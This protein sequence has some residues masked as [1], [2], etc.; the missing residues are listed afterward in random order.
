MAPVKKKKHPLQP[1]FLKAWRDKHDLGQ[2]EAAERADISRTLLSKMENAKIPYNQRTLEALARIYECTPAQLLTQN[3]DR[4]DSFVPLFEKL[5]AL[6]G[7]DRRQAYA[8]ICA[9][10]GLPSPE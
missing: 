3:P 4:P 8:V 5:E 7:P 6:E 9:T 1:T 10:L 2:E